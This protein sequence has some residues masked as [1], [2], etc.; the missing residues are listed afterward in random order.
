M[1]KNFISIYNRYEILIPLGLYSLYR[2]Q[3][4]QM[5]FLGPLVFIIVLW[6]NCCSLNV[7]NEPVLLLSARSSLL[8]LKM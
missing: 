4:K 1:N 2:K 5:K 3:M 7:V 6:G 8:I